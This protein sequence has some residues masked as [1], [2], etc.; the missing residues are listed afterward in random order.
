M[1]RPLTRRI[2]SPTSQPVRDGVVAVLRAR[3]PVRLLRGERGDGRFPGERVLERHRRLR[4][5][6]RARLGATTGRRRGR[7]PCRCAEL[8]PVLD[9]RRVDVERPALGELVRAHGRMPFVVEKTRTERVLFPRATGRGIGDT[10]PEVND[11]LAAVVRG[12][13]RAD[14]L[15]LG[16]V[17]RE[18]SR[19]RSLPRIRVRSNRAARSS[20]PL[21]HSVNC[22]SENSTIG[23]VGAR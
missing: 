18:R 1:R 10:A 15:P 9:D 6:R 23:H 7:S 3:F 21:A 19:A 13:R 8:G 14:L 17:P 4:S 20:S 12:E 16:E 2:T 5:T 22:A 11:L